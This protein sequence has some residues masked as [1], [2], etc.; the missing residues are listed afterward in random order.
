MQ[1][2][3]TDLLGMPDGSMRAVRRALRSA[4]GRPLAYAINDGFGAIAAGMLEQVIRGERVSDSQIFEMFARSPSITRARSAE[5]VGVVS[6]RGIALYDVDVQPIAFSAVKLARDVTAL[7]N[8]PLIKSIILDIDSPGGSVVG[9]PE[10]AAAVWSARKRKRVVGVVSPLCASAAYWIASQAD[11]LIA[12]QSADIGSIG[13][14][15]AHADCSRF[16][17]MQGVKVTY[18]HAGE[19][20]VEGNPNEPLS[21]AGKA[22]YQSEVNET[23]AE[24]VRAVARGRNVDQAKVLADF[25]KGRCLTARAAKK[26][27]MIDHIVSSPDDALKLAVSPSAMRAARLAELTV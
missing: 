8:D 19:F 22:H 9:I 13:V 1:G 3:L 25:G 14:F 23:Y 16:N 7:A 27:G 10:A 4:I 20:K 26:A 11:S 21:S 2:A 12:V 5:G 15:F 17:E 18:I 24:F 6:M